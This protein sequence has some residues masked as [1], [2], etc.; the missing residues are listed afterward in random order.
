MP[1][2]LAAGLGLATYG[3]LGYA[4]QLGLECLA[5]PWYAPCLAT[6]GAAV[7][8]FSWWQAP[9]RWRALALLAVV[10][11]AGAE[12]TVLLSPGLPEY[13]GPVTVGQ[14]FPA[15]S[16][17]YVDDSRFA[18]GDLKRERNTL[19][20]F[21]DAENPTYT[22]I[23][24]RGL[25]RRYE[26]FARR[27]T[28]VVAVSLADTRFAREM[29][30]TFPHLVVVSDWGGNVSE[31]AGLLPLRTVSGYRET[32]VVRTTILIDRGGTVRWLYRPRHGL[33]R[34]SPDEVLRAIDSHIP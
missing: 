15:F 10:L 3:V 24:L 17:F 27:K 14:P 21:P 20:V 4:A 33:E 5:T 23:E 9:T 19:L 34:L 11:L 1:L 7:L 25:D 29:Q 8:L 13:A 2:S 18:Q 6:L 22:E 12:W 16:T 30:V 26:D 28:R 32:T 31:A